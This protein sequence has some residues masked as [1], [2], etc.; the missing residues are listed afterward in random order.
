MTTHTNQNIKMMINLRCM[1]IFLSMLTI[2]VISNA[3]VSVAILG[4]KSDQSLSRTS[5]DFESLLELSLGM[6]DDIVLV[7]RGHLDNALDELAL[8]ASGAVNAKTA[9]KIGSLTGANVLISGRLMRIGDK[10]IVISKTMG[11]ETMRVFSEKVSFSDINMMEESADQLSEAIA[12]QIQANRSELF[13]TAKVADVRIEALQAR[14][15]K[16]KLPTL[17]VSIPEEHIGRLV[18][19]P[20]A[21]TELIR[22]LQEVGFTILDFKTEKA[23]D[24]L[25]TGEA[26]SEGAIQVNNLISCRARVEVKAT[27]A[28]NGEIIFSDATESTKIDVAENIAGKA[29]LQSAGGKIGILL[30]DRILSELEK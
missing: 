30:S 3:E 14:A 11:T 8:G 15:A 12:A 4:F 16:L 7:E 13:S 10:W 17:K 28:S 18:P 27:N 2:S 20:A 5:T 6:Q 23:P 26:F 21:Q 25:I 9:A 1:I 24:I 19:D 29:A 22:I